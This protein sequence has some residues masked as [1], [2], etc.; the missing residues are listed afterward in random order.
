VNNFDTVET[1]ITTA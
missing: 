1:H